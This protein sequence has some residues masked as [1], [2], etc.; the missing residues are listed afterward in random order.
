MPSFQKTALQLILFSNLPYIYKPLPVRPVLSSGHPWVRS[1]ITGVVTAE[2]LGNT[3][4]W[5]PP[6]RSRNV[7][8]FPGPKCHPVC[9]CVYVC[10]FVFG[11]RQP[12][13]FLSAMHGKWKTLCRD[14]L[15]S[16]GSPCLW[17][18][19]SLTCITSAF[20]QRGVSARRSLNGTNRYLF[21]RISFH[22]LSVT[23]NSSLLWRWTTPC[24]LE[25]KSW[26]FRILMT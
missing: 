13:C 19:T 6:G 2:P 16:R 4:D 15:W 21:T 8:R 18:V 25:H 14:I 10:V 26:M 9:V 11:P 23:F 1:V 17:W 5:A 20:V 24:V 7:S 22:R 3:T 12:L